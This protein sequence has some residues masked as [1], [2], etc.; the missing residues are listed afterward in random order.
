MLG[1]NQI[2][3]LK[4]RDRVII[5]LSEPLRVSGGANIAAILSLTR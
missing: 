1:F 5:S 4:C 3:G 2:S